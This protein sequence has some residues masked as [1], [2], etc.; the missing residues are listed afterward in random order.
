MTGS[1]GTDPEHSRHRAMPLWAAVTVFVVTA[2]GLAWLVALPLWIGR[3]DAAG[4]A[5]ASLLTP[6]LLEMV[7]AAAMMYT[8]TLAALLV[9]AL[10]RVPR[11]AWLGML[12]VWPLRPFKRLFWFML[13]AIVA[14][15]L[16]VGATLG[17]AVA[18]GWLRLD[19]LEFSGM[20]AL[21]DAQLAA[22]AELEG[23]TVAEMRA[24]LPPFGLLVAIQLLSMPLAAVLNTI[25]AIGEEAGW[26]GWLLPAL[27][28]LGHWPALLLSGLVWGVWHAPLTLL[29]HNFG[30]YDLRGVLVMTIGC[31]C[32]GVFFG[33]LR[34]RSGSV[35]PAAL[36]HGSLNAA[37]GMF[38]L[39]AAAEP[40][41]ELWLVNPL[42]VSGWIVLAIV[43][44]LI[45]V[46]PGLRLSS[47]DG[48]H[49][50][51]DTQVASHPRVSP[52]A[53]LGDD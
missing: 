6:G 25:L 15:I 8:P 51:T 19:L 37:G 11:R 26:R 27:R 35:W 42:G 16:L 43:A 13:G 17:V 33:W 34:L 9:L 39:L 4:G 32:W 22:A 31:V 50:H 40:P 30:L 7:I 36:A 5:E 3:S 38:L 46:I 41:F 18:C 21:I 44:L 45:A 24:M 48:E 20:A 12:G 1:V 23:E 10:Q 29:G 49:V 47:A 28:P 14:P 53:A 2:L 52:Q